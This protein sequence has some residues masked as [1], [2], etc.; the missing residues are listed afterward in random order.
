[1]FKKTPRKLALHRETVGEL[2]TPR[3]QRAAGGI[4]TLDTNCYTCN[5]S[6]PG[7]CIDF[8]CVCNPSWDCPTG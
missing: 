3:L 8:S 7:T 6:C 2:S 1:M 4:P 5:I